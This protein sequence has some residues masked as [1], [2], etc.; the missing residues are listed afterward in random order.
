MRQLSYDSAPLRFSDHRPVYATFACRVSI[1]DESRREQMSQELYQR[2]K[3]EV[4]EATAQASDGQESEDEDL[5]GHEA[6]EPGLPPA[7]SDRH[8]WWLDKQQPARAQVSVPTG[9]DGRAMALNPKRASNPFGPRDE[10]DWVRTSPGPSRPGTPGSR[11]EAAAAARKPLPRHDSVGLPPP[12]PPPPR[13][14]GSTGPRS[15]AS[16]GP[17]GGEAPRQGQGKGGGKAAPPVA[18][19]PAHLVG[20]SSAPTEHG[21][22]A[23]AAARTRGSDQ[24]QRTTVVG[25]GQGGGAGQRQRATAADLLDAAD[26]SAEMSGWETLQPSTRA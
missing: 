21:T 9:P 19:K 10:P 15:A 13:R 20:T 26:E 2:R 1:I 5:I 3:A 16:S 8:K 12:P 23:A 11:A 25:G 18:K 4:G 7:S 17:G 14:K 6:T 24:A 22:A